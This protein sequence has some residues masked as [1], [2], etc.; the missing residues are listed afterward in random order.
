EGIIRATE[1]AEAEVKRLQGELANTQNAIRMGEQSIRAATVPIVEE[2]V[3]AL[4]DP[5]KAVEQ[6]F[7]RLR[8]L[9]VATFVAGNVGAEDFRQQME[10]LRREQ[11]AATE[12]AEKQKKALAGVGVAVFRSRQQAIGIAGR[13]LQQAGL[14]VGENEQFGGV[15]GSHPGMG[16]AHGKYAIDV[17]V[18]AGIVEADVPDLRARFDALARRYQAR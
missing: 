17:N 12:Q 3:E 14:R 7:Q 9:L 18:G 2:Q 4:V 16:A 10:K 15:R 13:E 1:R 5:V 11:E 6:R 8:D